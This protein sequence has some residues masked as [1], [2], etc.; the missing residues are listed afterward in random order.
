MNENMT[1]FQKGLNEMLFNYCY[2]NKIT[3]Q[4][5]S[6]EIQAYPIGNTGEF[7]LVKVNDEVIGSLTIINNS[8]IHT[9]YKSS[10]EENGKV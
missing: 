8:I 9:T 7:N 6:V 1:Q 2:E 5:A 4:D 10:T 3:M